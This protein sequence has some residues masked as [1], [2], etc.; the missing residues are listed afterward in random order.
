MAEKFRSFYINYVP[1]ERMHM[2]MH[3]RSSPLH[4]L[5]Q[6][7]RRRKYLSI[8][9]TCT[10]HNSPLKAVRLAKEIF[11]LKRFLRLQQVR[12][13]GLAILIHWLHFI[14]HTTWRSQRG[15]CNQKE[16]SSILLQCDHM[17][18]VSSIAWQN[19]A[20]L[21]FTHRGTESTKGS[22]RWYVRSSP[23]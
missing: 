11:K 10:A 6:S 18:I 12:T 19:P 14:Q 21:S 16:S 2:Y 3:W 4:W 23:T 17:N 1:P 20:L 7:E 8:A 13:H 15:I 9:V 5:F 22:S